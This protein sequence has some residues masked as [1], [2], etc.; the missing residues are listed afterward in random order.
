MLLGVNSVKGQTIP[1]YTLE[2]LVAG[3]C[4]GADTVYILNFWATWCPPCIQEF[5][6][7]NKLAE[8]T[9]Q[10]PVKIYMVSMDD[11]R[12]YKTALALFVR[13]AQAVPEVVWLNE[14]KPDK[15]I[16]NI[17]KG[18][19]GTIPLTYVLSAKDRIAFIEGA[20]NAKDIE[21]KLKQY[22]AIRD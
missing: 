6:E 11:E 3:H 9:A 16:R 13:R 21:Q 14:P 15:A 17:Y 18:W 1:A 20:I 12:T 5:P 22:M 7:L 10:M 4:N 8:L 19:Q 2:Q